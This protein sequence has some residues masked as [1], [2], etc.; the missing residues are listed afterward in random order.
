MADH[1]MR[2]NEFHF[3]GAGTVYLVLRGVRGGGH[4]YTGDRHRI[5]DAVIQLQTRYF[6]PAFRHEGSHVYAIRDGM[7][8]CVKSFTRIEIPPVGC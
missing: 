3:P 5:A 1:I 6:A 7:R 2:A 8:L 4:G